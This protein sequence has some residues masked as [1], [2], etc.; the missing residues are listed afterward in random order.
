MSMSTSSSPTYRYLKINKFYLN[1]CVEMEPRGVYSLIERLAG[2]SLLSLLPNLF[3]KKLPTLPLLLYL[4]AWGARFP[5]PDQSSPLCGVRIPRVLCKQRTLRNPRQDESHL[6]CCGTFKL[7]SSALGR[8]WGG[9]KHSYF[10]AQVD[11]VINYHYIVT[12]YTTGYQSTRIH[13]CSVAPNVLSSR[14]MFWG[15][16]LHP[17]P[18]FLHLQCPITLL[19][20]CLCSETGVRNLAQIATLRR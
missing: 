6:D 13:S 15:H 7:A 17:E 20:I 19:G 3:L 5:H 2:S 18:T 11:S 16:V 8:R 4:Q 10:L 14:I 1:T 9:G 12:T